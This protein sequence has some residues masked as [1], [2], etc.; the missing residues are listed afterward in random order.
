MQNRNLTYATEVRRISGAVAAGTGDTIT[1]TEVDMRGYNSVLFLVVLGAVTATGTA[2]LNVKASDTS[3]TYG[4][5]TIDT[6]ATAAQ[7]ALATTGDS[8]KVMSIEVFKPRRRYLRAQLVRAT[9]NIAVESVI[10][11]L[12]NAQDEPTTLAAANQVQP[13]SVLNNPVPSAS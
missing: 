7:E 6:L 12:Y 10:A 2:R 5:G 1:F 9:A 8:N 11:I 13:A 4:A 3:A